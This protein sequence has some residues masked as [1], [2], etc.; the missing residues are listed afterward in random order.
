MLRF[1][2]LLMVS[3]SA[4]VAQEYRGTVLGRI[5]D[6]SGAVVVGASIQVTNVETNVT[7]SAAANQEGNY[8]V[9]F[10]LPGNYVVRVE[11]A[12]FKKVERPGVRVSVGAQVTLNF[13][14][15]VGAAAE[16]VTVTASSPLLNV[17]GADLGQVIQKAYVEFNAQKSISIL[18]GGSTRG[19]NEFLVDGIP[20][21]VIH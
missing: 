1:V 2:V 18:G 8:Q 10:L 17:A 21:T 3:F 12:G 16:T 6:S 11:H 7:V 5:T 9:P 14:L 4:V 19:G 13:A 15:E 20:N